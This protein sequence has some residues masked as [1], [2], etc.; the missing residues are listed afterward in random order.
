MMTFMRRLWPGSHGD[1]ELSGDKLALQTQL[2]TTIAEKSATASENG[3]GVLAVLDSVRV[4]K[5][6]RP[7]R[8]FSL[9]LYGKADGESMEKLSDDAALATQFSVELMSRRGRMPEEDVNSLRNKL[10][11][12]R[13][14]N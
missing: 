5:F 7:G 11:F 10:E 14:L 2:Q 13:A 6:D 3:K 9:E 4:A 8:L 1:L 12:V